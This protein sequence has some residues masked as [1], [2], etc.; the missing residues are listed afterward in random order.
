MAL[1]ATFA[2]DF[3]TFT[4]ACAKAEVSL[5]GIESG[6]SA[7]GSKLT[8]MGDSLSGNKNIQQ[9]ALLAGAVERVGGVSVLTATELQRVGTVATEA[10]EKLRVL[11]QDVP[12]GIQKIAEAAKAAEV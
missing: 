7:G 9:A 10:A 6:A 1:S 2:A 8:R 5:K 4:N 12:P 3:S 11:G